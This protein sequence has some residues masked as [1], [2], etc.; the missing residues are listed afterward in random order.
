MLSTNIAL[1]PPIRSIS[2]TAKSAF[3]TT[4]IQWPF[5]QASCKFRGEICWHKFLEGV[6]CCHGLLYSGWMSKVN[7]DLAVQIP[8][9]YTVA[10]V[11]LLNGNPVWTGERV[12]LWWHVR[13]AII[14]S[15][16]SHSWYRIVSRGKRFCCRI[17][18]LKVLR[19]LAFDLTVNLG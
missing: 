19:P 3:T 17:L 1:F 8:Y 18:G 16:R 2:A 11:A 15:P 9:P 10:W 6:K 13:W 14:D 12:L 5:L 7:S 4:P